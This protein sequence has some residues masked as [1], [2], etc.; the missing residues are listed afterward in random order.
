MTMWRRRFQI[1]GPKIS[2]QEVQN[3]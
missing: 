2:Q 3:A 1:T